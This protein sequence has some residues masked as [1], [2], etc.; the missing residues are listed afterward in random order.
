M[1]IWRDKL[2]VCCSKFM[3]GATINILGGAT[4][5]PHTFVAPSTC[6]FWR[7]KVACYVPKLL[8]T[9]DVAK[10]LSS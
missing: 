8:V 2:H 7:P 9:F 10:F 3:F 5:V 1:Y 6:G 4:K